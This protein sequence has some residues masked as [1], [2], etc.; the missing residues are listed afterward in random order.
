MQ[1]IF[2]FPWL[3]SNLKTA[4][5]SGVGT[6]EALFKD[7]QEALCAVKDALLNPGTHP[8]DQDISLSQIVSDVYPSSYCGVWDVWR[9]TEARAG[10]IGYMENSVDSTVQQPRFV[11]LAN[12]ATDI[13][14]PEG[15]NRV[16]LDGT[17]Y[18]PPYG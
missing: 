5:I 14:G 13:V 6:T 1:M 8:T 15:T 3:L 18:R 4:N 9:P 2:S 11:K 12:V 7:F 10:D 16:Q 17:V